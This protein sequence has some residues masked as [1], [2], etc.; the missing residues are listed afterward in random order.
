MAERV[1]PGHYVVDTEH[2][3]F[4]RKGVTNDIEYGVIRGDTASDASNGKF[5][6]EFGFQRSK[7]YAY[8][9]TRAKVTPKLKFSPT[10]PM[11][12]FERRYVEIAYAQQEF[13]SKSDAVEYAEEQ[14]EAG[15]HI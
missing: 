8:R 10:A 5:A 6:S 9:S 1:K 2:D 15:S 11:E 12:A 14:A 3:D 13:D 7:W 4:E